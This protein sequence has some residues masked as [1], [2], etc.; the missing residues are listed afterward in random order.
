MDRGMSVEEL[1]ALPVS[2]DLPTA[3]RAFGI[4]RTKAH[5]LAR[6]GVF[7]C[8]VLRV[9]AK[10]RVPRAAIYE[11]LGLALTDHDSDGRAAKPADDAA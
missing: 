8:R 4:G 1:R 11:A 6:R 9:G 3:G 10:Y 5:E 2:V 7:P